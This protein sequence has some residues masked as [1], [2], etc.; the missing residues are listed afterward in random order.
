MSL[1]LLFLDGKVANVGRQDI[2]VA[3]QLI[4]LRLKLSQSQ[5][6]LVDVGDLLESGRLG[7]AQRCHF[8]AEIVA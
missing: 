8:S 3:D 7:L 2:S 4:K 5:Q 6:A 1:V